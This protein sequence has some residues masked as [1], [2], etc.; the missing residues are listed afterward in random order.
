MAVSEIP[1]NITREHLLKAIERID[2]EGLPDKGHSSTYDVI[3]DGKVYP[4]KVVVSWAN[5]FANCEGGVKGDAIIFGE[6]PVEY[7]KILIC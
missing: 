2:K 7:F 1:Q 4:P 3:H 5:V 6:G